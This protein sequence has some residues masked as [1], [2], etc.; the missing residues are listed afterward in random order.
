MPKIVSFCPLRIPARILFGLF[1][2]P[3]ATWKE[4]ECLSRSS[5]AGYLEFLSSLFVVGDE[6][7][8]Q[9]RKK[10]LAVRAADL[11]ITGFMS[12]R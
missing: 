9:L 10:R 5:S 12:V 4:M 11:K 1:S 7:L 2:P 3:D 8:F 6:K